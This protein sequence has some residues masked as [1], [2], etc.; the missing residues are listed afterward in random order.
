MSEKKKCNGGNKHIKEKFPIIL[1]EM[2]GSDKVCF[3]TLVEATKQ[4]ITPLIISNCRSTPCLS[5]DCAED[6][7]IQEVLIQVFTTSVSQFFCRP[8]KAEMNTSP[9]EY[10]FWVK[11]ICKTKTINAF[12]KIAKNENRKC[13]IWRDEDGEEEEIDIFDT[14][15]DKPEIPAH[16]EPYGSVAQDNAEDMLVDCFNAV[17]TTGGN[18]YKPLTWLIQAVF[19]LKHN[20]TRIEANDLMEKTLG[21]K[22]L[23]EIFDIILSM[24]GTIS[25]MYLEPESIDMIYKGL[26]KKD[27]SGRRVG[28]IKYS[29]CYMA[30]GPKKSYS[31]WVNREDGQINKKFDETEDEDKADKKKSKKSDDEESEK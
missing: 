24:S 9:D 28:D 29:E 30:A 2:F 17:M 25:W 19:V 10:W 13:F 18:V 16:S 1:E 7:I 15:P 12:K 14:I 20:M 8:E 27:K 11:S 31:D 26:E 23:S 5:R 22:T 21:D 6:D 3:D 4:D